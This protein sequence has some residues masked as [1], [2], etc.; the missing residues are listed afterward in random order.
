MINSTVKMMPP[1]IVKR[2]VSRPRLRAVAGLTSKAPLAL[3]AMASPSCGYLGAHKITGA[4]SSEENH[5]CR[6]YINYR[7]CAHCCFL[8]WSPSQAKSTALVHQPEVHS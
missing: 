5:H 4:E 1:T 6:D 3:L 2:K 8:A 7:I